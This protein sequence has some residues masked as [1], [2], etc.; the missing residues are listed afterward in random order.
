MVV[1]ST[2]AR[3]ATLRKHWP[4]YVATNTELLGSC[5]MVACRGLMPKE[6]ERVNACKRVLT[7]LACIGMPFEPYMR[8]CRSF[9]VSKVAYGW[10]ARAPPLTL[11]KALFSCVHMGSRRLRSASVW[12]RAALFGGGLH[13]DVLFATQLVGILSRVQ[14]RRALTW[15]SVSG[16]PARALNDWLCSHGWICDADWKWSHALSRSVLDFT[17]V[18]NAGARQHV[19]RTA[20]RAWCPNK[21]CQSTRRDNNLDCFENGLFHRIDWDGIRKF[22]ASGPEARA[23]A[24]GGSFSPAALHSAQNLD[25]ADTCIWPGCHDVGSFDHIAWSCPCRPCNMDIPPKPG[26][27]LVARFGWVI[28]RVD[29]DMDRV[30]AWLVFVQ[31][32]IWELRHGS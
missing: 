10:I 14:R 22:A 30:H 17:V 25:V 11:C 23:L 9:A 15:S 20:W 26:E 6:L 19:V 12:L 31:R 7:L 3:R 24:T 21:H 2:P 5:S 1:A 28:S 8:A 4:D 27:F 13:L 16:T 29:A 32:T 18:D